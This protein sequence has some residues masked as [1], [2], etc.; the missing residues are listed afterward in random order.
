MSETIP[1]PPDVQQAVDKIMETKLEEVKAMPL[2][3]RLW[4]MQTELGRVAKE[5]TNESQRYK[6]LRQTDIVARITE[7]AA[8]YRVLIIFRQKVDA[9]TITSL[10]SANNKA[11]TGT[12]VVQ[13]YDVLNIDNPED[14]LSALLGDGELYSQG[15]SADSGDKSLYKAKTGA[16]KYALTDT[17]MVSSGD[18][19]EAAGLA[20]EREPG[21]RGRNRPNPA[22]G[23]GGRASEAQVRAWSNRR[24]SRRIPAT[25]AIPSIGK[26]LGMAINLKPGDVADFL[27]SLSAR[28]MSKVLDELNALPT[29]PPAE[30]QT[31]AAEQPQPQPAVA[32]RIPSAT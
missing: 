32:P 24:K 13:R 7:L 16:N 14:R 9:T 25:L 20:D 12:S 22:E 26:A 18:D 6:Y 19:A 30:K 23:D 21:Q 5:G 15:Y 17:F 10:M 28:D 8:K 11:M 27:R 4:H 3:I 31:P 29:P 2:V 1:T